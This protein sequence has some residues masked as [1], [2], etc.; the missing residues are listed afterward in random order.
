MKTVNQESPQPQHMTTRFQ[1]IKDLVR[2]NRRVIV[3]ELAEEDIFNK[4]I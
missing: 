1:K 2:V 4:K 3:K